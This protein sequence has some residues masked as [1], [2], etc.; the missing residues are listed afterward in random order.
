M[1]KYLTW[2]REITGLLKN[3]FK[4]EI[5]KGRKNIYEIS[6]TKRTEKPFKIEGVSY[7]QSD[8]TQKQ[9]QKVLSIIEKIKG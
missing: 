7:M 4:P 3:G 1:K 9:L 2:N 8:F 6:F 5:F